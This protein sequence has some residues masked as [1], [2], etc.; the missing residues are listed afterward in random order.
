M[1]LTPYK[2]S[3]V[4]IRGGF[5]TSAD[6][7]A[8]RNIAK[9]E[10]GITW[11]F[12]EDIPTRAQRGAGT[13]GRRR[14][15]SSFLPE[16]KPRLGVWFD[17]GGRGRRQGKELDETI[18]AMSPSAWR[19]WNTEAGKQI[20]VYASKS[21]FDTHIGETGHDRWIAAWARTTACIIPTFPGS[22]SCSSNGAARWIWI[23]CIV[24][25]SYFGDG[26]AGG[27]EPRPYEG[28]GMRALGDGAGGARRKEW[29]NG[30]E[31]KQKL[32]AWFYDLVQ[33]EVNRMLGG[34]MKLRKR[35]SRSRRAFLPTF[36]TARRASEGV[37]AL[38]ARQKTALYRRGDRVGEKSTLITAT[39]SH[40]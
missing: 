39:A 15:V 31:R 3:F 10:L 35:N 9:C 14:L 36:R 38:L 4:I 22:A 7:W 12:T 25:L 16:R 37:R 29:G 23:F 21:W 2:D 18:T 19:L 17:M 20:G 28:R 1:D 13:A 24:P 8:E 5:W 33:G 6:P 30:E 27:A 34:E 40:E 11:G 32:G 26:A